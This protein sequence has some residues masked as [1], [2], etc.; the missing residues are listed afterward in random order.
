MATTMKAC[1]KTISQKDTASL[2]H[3]LVE[4]N[5]RAIGWSVGHTV[6]AHITLTLRTQHMS[7]TLIGDC[8]LAKARWSFIVKASPIK[9]LGATTAV[10]AKAT[11]PTLISKEM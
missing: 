2:S 11:K 1:L 6:T 8:E 9:V 3:R 7:A 10:L 4:C 5:I